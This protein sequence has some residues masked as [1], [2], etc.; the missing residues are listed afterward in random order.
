M[1]RNAEKKINNSGGYVS[2]K[3]TIDALEFLLC[4]FKREEAARTKNFFNLLALIRRHFKIKRLD[5]F[6]DKTMLRFNTC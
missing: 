4:N 1:C 6:F 2:E 3:I 5:F